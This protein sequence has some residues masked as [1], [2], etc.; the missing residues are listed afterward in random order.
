M[1]LKS[2]GK[3]RS[4]ERS[5]RAVN[6]GYS[7]RAE[8]PPGADGRALLDFLVE[9]WR[10][11]D[12][13]AWRARL[14]RGEVR[15]GEA[16][17]TGDERLRAGQLL[18]WQRPPWE[19]PPAPLGF[20][21]LHRD[22]H[23]LAVGKPAGLPSMPSGG[24]YLEHTLLHQV[25]RRFPDATLVHRLD[26]GT[27]GALLLARTPAARRAFSELFQSGRIE[28]L[29]RGRIVGSP[30]DETFTIDAPIGEVAHPA[31]GRA[32]AVTA[33]GRRSRTEVK[34]VERDGAT[35]LVEIRIESGRP[36]QIR[37][38]LAWAG[39]PLVGEPFF[40]AGGAPRIDG[41]A[42]PGDVGYALH[43][44]SLRCDHPLQDG[45]LHVW[46]AP[47]PSLRRDGEIP[48]SSHDE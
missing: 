47:P 6:H 23:V 7:H 29:Y 17:A 14:E 43:A 32:F 28:R 21:L 16:V 12:A 30:S 19:E 34:V 45:P 41:G 31:I 38:H 3:R 48:A 36:H 4:A 24:R 22:D 27:S 46:C 9:T 33:T 25:R 42:R 40:L 44:I 18:C 5:R 13:A 15:L 11:G 37:I 35:S 10:H 2:R 20:A 26:R 1:R 8:L 39:F